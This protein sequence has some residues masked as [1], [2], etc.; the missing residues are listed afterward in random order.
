MVS[1]IYIHT[2][3]MYIHTHKLRSSLVADIFGTNDRETIPGTSEDDNIFGLAGNDILEGKRND[4]LE[5]NLGSNELFSGRENDTLI[6]LGIF[7]Q[8]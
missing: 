8:A 1:L 3:S 7:S 4:R 6:S 2:L 5:G